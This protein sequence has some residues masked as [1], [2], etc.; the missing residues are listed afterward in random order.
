MRETLLLP[1]TNKLSVLLYPQCNGEYA[2]QMCRL[3]TKYRTFLKLH[4]CS[5]CYKVHVV[6]NQ[7]KS[8]ILKSLFVWW[9]WKDD[10]LQIFLYFV[11]LY[12]RNVLLDE[13][14]E[15]PNAIVQHLFSP[16]SDI[17]C[18]HQNPRENNADIKG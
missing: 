4:D 5:I 15:K 17:L 10:K 18:T 8:I 9:V 2:L 1:Q 14:K 7:S 12:I 11:Y 16:T 3:Q 13:T 6:P